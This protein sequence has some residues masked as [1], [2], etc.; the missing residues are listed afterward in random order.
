M[1]NYPIEDKINYRKVLKA[2]VNLSAIVDVTE[3]DNH[4]ILQCEDNVKIVN[5]LK[6][7]AY[8]EIYKKLK[9]MTPHDIKF[10]EQT[11]PD[12]SQID[13]NQPK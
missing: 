8:Y 10:V 4:G 6:E 13:I 5:S 9:A 2:T 12:F 7:M 1:K 3:L 11:M